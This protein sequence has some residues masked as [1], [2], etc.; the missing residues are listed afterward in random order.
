MASDV[1]TKEIL[2]NTFDYNPE[3]GRLIRTRRGLG[4][5]VGV[6]IGSVEASG[7]RRAYF[8][9]KNRMTAHLVWLWHH[10]ALPK[11]ILKHV[12]GIN[13]DDRIE[14]LEIL[15]QEF[16]VSESVDFGN[17]QRQCVKAG[18][19]GI[20]AICCIENGRQYVG[21]AVDVAKRW[22][23]H[24]RHLS[25]GRHHSKHLQRAWN[26]YGESSFVFVV[27]EECSKSELIEMEQKHI[28]IMK[29]KFNSRP[30]AASQLGFKMSDESK[31]KLS[32]SAKRTKN[33]TGHS[34]SEETKARISATK[35]GIKV[36]RYDDE[37][38]KKTAAAMR[39]GKNAITESQVMAIRDL[40]RQGLTAAKIAKS[41]GCKVWPV[42]DVLQGKTYKW[43]I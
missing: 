30:M 28:D 12:N 26:K 35:T 33:F 43:V 13:S 18:I 34:H 4:A 5:R 29:P 27:L 38:V 37:R 10:G 31:A 3:T 1:L 42:Y 16:N 21:S 22:K 24:H 7:H 25:Q 39:A 41:V 11:H 9:G 32:E 40:K 19:I 36:G 15:R 23:L 20:Y 2:K 6:E 17:C 14:N 8:A